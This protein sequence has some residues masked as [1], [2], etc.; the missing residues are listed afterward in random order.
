M[1]IM[2]KLFL[3]LF[4][5]TSLITQA[6]I[7]VKAGLNFANITKA[8]EINNT[9]RTGY[10]VGIF[11]AGSGKSIISSHTEFLYSRQGYD[12]ATNTNTGHVDL[13]YFILPQFMAINIT[14]YVQIQLG[15]QMAYLLNA[16]VDSTS[17]STGNQS[18]DKILDLVN[19]FDYG[20]GGGVEVH[21][22]NALALGARINFS[23]GKLF[24]VPENGEV[25]SFIPDIDV[26]N[27]LFQIYA[28]FKFGKE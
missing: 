28:G 8:D 25:P 24:K 18:T 7:G 14:K 21:P 17:T 2:K 15:G 9:S 19:R 5:F 23:L 12:F 22:V 20:F 6:Q 1:K 4:L 11:L 13:D 26:R 3:A 10:H 16:K 27:N